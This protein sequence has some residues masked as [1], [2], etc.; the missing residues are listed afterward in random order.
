MDF[1]SAK[2]SLSAD[3]EF[4][5]SLPVRGATWS[6]LRQGHTLGISIHAPREGSD[7]TSYPWATTAWYFNPRSPEGERRSGMPPIIPPPAFQSTLP[8][9]GA[10]KPAIHGQQRPGISIRAPRK[11]SDGL[12]CLQSYHHRHFNPRSPG[13]ERPLPRSGVRVERRFQSTLPGRGATGDGPQ[14]DG[15]HQISIHA[16]RE[17]SDGA[18]TARPSTRWNFNPRSPGGE[19]RTVIRTTSAPLPISIHAPREGSDWRWSTS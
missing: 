19:R 2:Q 16:P 8:V 7:K 3:I 13:G 17:G 15:Y 18:N 10:T 9:R 5:S 4:Q 1:L 6:I 12:V 14:A 11:G